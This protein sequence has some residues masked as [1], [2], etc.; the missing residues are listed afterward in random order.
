MWNLLASFGACVWM[1]IVL[2][3]CR[4]WSTREFLDAISS[5][6]NED[7]SDIS[8]LIPA[9]NEK[10]TIGATLA[11]INAQG[12]GLN[13]I[14][15][16][17]Q[18]N[19]GTADE[20]RKTS[21]LNLNIISGSPLPPGWSGKLWAL[22]QGRNFVNTPLTLLIDADIVLQPGILVALQNMMR[23]NDLSL[24]SLMAAMRMTSFWERLLMP[25]F[26]FFFKL[27][28]PF[29]LSNSGLSRVAAA[30]GGCI[31]LET[32]VLDDI[33]GFKALRGELIDDCALGRIVKSLGFKTWIGLTHSV[34]SLRAYDDL[35]AIWNMV[36]RTAFTQ[37]RY[38]YLLLAM[39][40][41]ILAVAFW[42]PAVSLAIGTSAARYITA[43]AFCGMIFSYLPVLSFYRMSRWWAFTMPVIGTLYLGMTWTSAI[44]YLKG[45]RSQWK[46][47]TYS[48]N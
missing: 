19:D 45:E 5:S 2:M 14:V 7:L 8:V 11:S 25:A 22:E 48:R 44:R 31:L 46:G 29:Q 33:G 36:S 4:P 26:V 38:S 12:C 37:L 1:A 16:D 21:G 42:V 18:S 24:V 39:Y 40:T 10:E 15:I 43:V 9:R 32:R 30:A 13:I 27:L 23:Q 35:R 3:P 47:R 41:I 34:R 20:A 28:Y 17:D 6:G